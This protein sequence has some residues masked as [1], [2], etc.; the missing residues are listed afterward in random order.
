[1][2]NEWKSRDGE[3]FYLVFSKL[4]SYFVQPYKDHTKLFYSS[5]ILNTL[6][7]HGDIY[8]EDRKRNLKIRESSVIKKK[9]KKNNKKVNAVYSNDT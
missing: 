8:V 4:D 9:K 7:S 3:C 1:M 5:R 6:D 2:K